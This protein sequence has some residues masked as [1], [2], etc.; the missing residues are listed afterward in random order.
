MATMWVDDV[1]IRWYEV[2][3]NIGSSSFTTRQQLSNVSF[4]INVNIILF[5]DI[6]RTLGS[7]NLALV[8]GFRLVRSA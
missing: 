3:N 7:R 8:A 1:Y 4:T 5:F 6:D 2:Q